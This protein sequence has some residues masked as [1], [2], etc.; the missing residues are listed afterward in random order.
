MGAATY[1]RISTDRQEH[2]ETIQ[3]QLAELRDRAKDDG[4]HLLHE[5]IDEGYS[6]DDLVRPGLDRLRDLVAVGDVDRV[7]IQSPDRLA[8]GARLMLLVEEFQEHGCTVVFLRGSVD[9]TPE[10]K[11]LLGMQGL[12]ADYERTKIAERTRRGKLY[13]ARRG[14]LVGGHAPYGYHFVR[15]TDDARAS[16]KVDEARAPIV[17]EMYRWLADEHM[18]TR[19]IA[20][21]LTAEG[22]AT[23]RGA[24]QWQPTAVDRIVRNPTY[25]GVFYY[26][27][28]RS[29]A[30]S[31]RLTADRYKQRRK[32]GREA[33]PQRDWIAIPVPAIVSEALWDAAQQQLHQ[34]SLHS[35]R[36]NKRHPYLLRG[37]IRCPRCGGVYHGY[38]KKDR[39]WYRCARTDAT[40]SS[41]GQRCS[42]GSIP[43]EAVEDA[44]WRAV[45][46]AFQQPG[47]LRTEFEQRMSESTSDA[48]V[49]AERKQISQA[50]KRIAVQED[51][52]TDAYVN[53]VMDL[54][55]YKTEMD[56]LRQRMAELARAEREAIRRHQQMMDSRQALAHLDSFCEQVAA[57][58]GELT[59]EERQQL[60]RLLVERVTVENGVVRIE[61]IVPLDGGQPIPSSP[62]RPFGSDPTGHLRARRPELVEGRLRQG[63]GSWP[64]R[65][66]YRQNTG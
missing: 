43:A 23:S 13:W 36:N 58:L 10:G 60:M 12:F 38:A 47:A 9:D 3:S 24:V 66:R 45:T 55:H 7:F 14:A 2:E 40:V 20:R 39:R 37:L 65:P 25:R 53:E 6:R 18:S 11:M 57:G 30:P 22:V 35:L 54:E 15:R 28:A 21:R 16:L 50:L 42:P 5:F 59:F 63:S 26:Q 17:R 1:G 19:A 48:A 31:R 51:R 52:I 62:S 33:R 8:S 27:R 64:R 41:T 4:H 46:E 29:V 61:A 49:D 34:N 56:K 32:T 44:V